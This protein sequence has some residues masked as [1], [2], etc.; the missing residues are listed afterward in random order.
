[1]PDKPTERSVVLPIHAAEARPRQADALEDEVVALFDELRNGVLRYLRSFGLP[2]QDAEEVLQEVF[3]ALF[4]HL[5][6]GK[7]RD[8]LRGWVFRVAHNLALKRRREGP[9]SMV[10]LDACLAVPNLIDPTPNPEDQ[11]A[12]QQEQERLLAVF[13]A[14]PEV[15]RNCLTLRAEGLRYREIGEILEMSLGAVSA[16][17][18]RSLTRLTRA[19]EH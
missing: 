13:R 9:H 5:R 19:L 16:C 10:D 15:D 1:M 6:K 17:L 14:L 2:A 8:N 4:Q 3:L 7:R 12:H 11:F 18:G